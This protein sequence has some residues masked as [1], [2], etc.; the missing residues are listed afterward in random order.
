MAVVLD[1]SSTNHCDSDAQHYAQQH[2][3]LLARLEAWGQAWG[4]PG[5]LQRLRR[6]GSMFDM[7]CCSALSAI[8]WAGMA[9]KNLAS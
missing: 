7:C 4:L 1:R 9:G 2:A 8:L 6:L 3:I 5:L